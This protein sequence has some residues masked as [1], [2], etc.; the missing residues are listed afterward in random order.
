M[1]PIKSDSNLDIKIC[2]FIIRNLKF[3]KVT[4]K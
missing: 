3:E 2:D 4:K 1:G